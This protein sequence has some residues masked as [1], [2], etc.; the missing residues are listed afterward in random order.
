[1]A[2]SLE[3]YG[4]GVPNLDDRFRDLVN[5]TWQEMVEDGTYDVL[6]RY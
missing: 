2:S 1:M 4:L 5:F 3:P 6:Y